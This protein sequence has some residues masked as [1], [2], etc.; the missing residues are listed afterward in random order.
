[1]DQ[2]TASLLQKITKLEQQMTKQ[3]IAANFVITHIIDLL[4]DQSGDERFSSKLKD[5]LSESLNKLD[6]GMSAPIKSAINDLLEPSIKER[7]K[8]APDKF[9]K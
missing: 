1:M 8:P 2:Q 3:G 6:H 4:D 5:S 9:I 7:F